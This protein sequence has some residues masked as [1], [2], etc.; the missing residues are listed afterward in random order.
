[1]WILAFFIHRLHSLFAT[2]KMARRFIC[3]TCQRLFL[4]MVSFF[5]FLSECLKHFMFYFL[6]LVNNILTRFV[7]RLIFGE[8]CHN[9]ILQ[10]YQSSQFVSSFRCPRK[11]NTKGLTCLI[12][13]VPKICLRGWAWVPGTCIYL[14]LPTG[15]SSSP[16]FFFFAIF[17][18]QRTYGLLPGNSFS[19]DQSLT[20]LQ[21]LWN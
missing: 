20:H 8:V 7:I 19:L 4:S 9:Q 11:E 6:H 13:C 5:F 16:F 15:P 1:M 2:Y 21:S 14:T 12:L 18:L 17:K 10:K 3:D